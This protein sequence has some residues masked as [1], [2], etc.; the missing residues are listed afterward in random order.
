MLDMDK[1]MDGTLWMAAEENERAGWPASSS[2]ILAKCLL[3]N[4][5]SNGYLNLLIN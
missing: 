4:M 5:Y 1:D 3:I 2:H